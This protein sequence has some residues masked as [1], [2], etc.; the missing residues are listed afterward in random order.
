MKSK[1]TVAKF[2]HDVRNPLGVVMAYAQLIERSLS[3]TDSADPRML[4]QAKGI[5]RAANRIEELIATFEKTED[6]SELHE[7]PPQ[8]TGK[9]HL[10]L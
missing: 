10:S 5:V 8:P 2:A 3:A 1:K 7:L 4:R 6:S 9:K